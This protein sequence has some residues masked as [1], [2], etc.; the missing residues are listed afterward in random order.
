MLQ[1]GLQISWCII[2]FEDSCRTSIDYGDSLSMAHSPSSPSFDL[3]Y[4]N[5]SWRRDGCPDQNSISLIP[6]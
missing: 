3:V 2:A 4:R 6:G 1:L 5:L